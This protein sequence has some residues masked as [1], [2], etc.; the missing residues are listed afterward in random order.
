MKIQHLTGGSS[1]RR[2]LVELE[3]DIE[4][5]LSHTDLLLIVDNAKGIRYDRETNSYSL[6]GES[7][8]TASHFGG[9]VEVLPGGKRRVTVYID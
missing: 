5:A 6:T 3:T 4:R 2:A 7:L 1:Y 8:G 9:H